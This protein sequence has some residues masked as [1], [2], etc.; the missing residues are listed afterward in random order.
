MSDISG[1][2]GALPEWLNSSNKTHALELAVN[3]L[4]MGVGNHLGETHSIQIPTGKYTVGSLSGYVQ[5]KLAPTV[6]GTWDVLYNHES[7]LWTFRVQTVSRFT[8]HWPPRLIRG[9]PSQRISPKTRMQCSY[10]RYTLDFTIIR[11]IVVYK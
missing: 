3:S 1:I 2:A 7:K 9:G 5:A 8:S 11:Q 10:W 6:G 4:D